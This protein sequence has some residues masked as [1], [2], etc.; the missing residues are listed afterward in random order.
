MR[1]FI[2]FFSGLLLLAGIALWTCPA[3]L[4]YR[5]YGVQLSPVTLSDLSG[6][7]WQGHAGSARAFNRDLGALDWQLEAWPLLHG[8]KVAQ[9]RLGGRDITASGTV[10]S[11]ADGRLDFRDALIQLPADLLEPAIGVP[12]LHL[13]GRIDVQ[14]THLRVHQVWVEDAH[15]SAVWHDAAVS[16]AAQARLSE[17]AASF[18]SPSPGNIKGEVHDLGGPLEAVGAFQL[19]LTGYDAQLRL[20]ARNNDPHVLEALQFVGQPQTD[21]SVSLQIA[22]HLLKAF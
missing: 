20:A 17:I 5:W 9:L 15:G 4:A 19:A 7:L 22:G 13:L 8:D 1:K 14:L 6:S 2:L 18:R 21:G 3:E 11:T 12:N 16:G 10:T